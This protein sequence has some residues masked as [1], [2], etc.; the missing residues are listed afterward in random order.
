V[1]TI[2]APFLKFGNTPLHNAALCGHKEIVEILI[3]K[4]VDIEATGQVGTPLASV[5][6]MLHTYIRD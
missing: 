4:G 5:Y 1:A 2:Y 6:S 3:E